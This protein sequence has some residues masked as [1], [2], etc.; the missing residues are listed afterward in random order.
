MR[1]MPSARVQRVP[2][3]VARRYAARAAA[4][5]FRAG[6]AWQ[7][8]KVTPPEPPR[9]A[10]R[11]QSAGGFNAA[12]AYK[13]ARQNERQRRYPLASG[14][15]CRA[16]ARKPGRRTPASIW[17]LS[18]GGAMESTRTRGS[19]VAVAIVAVLALGLGGA[20][21]AKPPSLDRAEADAIR[22]LEQA[23]WGPNEALIAPVKSI[24]A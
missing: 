5:R 23:T 7:R 4:P 9:T 16:K 2:A 1:S 13:N 22:L 6:V 12:D 8:R 15:T 21:A 11:R 14:R 17:G 24:R 3:S 19:H 10:A 18:K 20:P